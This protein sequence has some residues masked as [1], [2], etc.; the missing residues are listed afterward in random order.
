MAASVTRK[1]EDSLLLIL[2]WNKNIVHL[3][4]FKVRWSQK[5]T[6]ERN[7]ST[8]VLVTFAD[9]NYKYISSL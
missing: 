2:V 4:I 1:N 6:P 7:N 9:I 5:Y 8:N 3:I